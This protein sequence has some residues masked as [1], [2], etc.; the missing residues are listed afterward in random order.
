MQKSCFQ[1]DVNAYLQILGP[2]N[3]NQHKNRK[4]CT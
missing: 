4:L 1:G 3:I 2:Q